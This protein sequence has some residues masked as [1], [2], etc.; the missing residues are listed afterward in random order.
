MADSDDHHLKLRLKVDRIHFDEKCFCVWQTAVSTVIIQ[1]CWVCTFAQ[2]LCILDTIYHSVLRFVRK[3][4]TKKTKSPK[5]NT[6]FFCHCG[7]LYLFMNPFCLYSPYL[8]IQITENCRGGYSRS[9]QDSLL[10]TVPKALS[11]NMG[12]ES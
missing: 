6:F 8:C 11:T 7:I 4:N 1:S 2:C 3:E 12:K 5:L 9:S 10:L